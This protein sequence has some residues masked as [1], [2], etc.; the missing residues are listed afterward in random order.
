[1]SYTFTVRRLE[2]CLK[3]SEIS[4]IILNQ[5]ILLRCLLTFCA[6]FSWAGSQP[7]KGNKNASA[8]ESCS[9]VFRPME[10]QLLGFKK[11]YESLNAAGIDYTH[12][13][14]TMLDPHAFFPELSGIHFFHV[15]PEEKRALAMGVSL[16]NVFIRDYI[17]KTHAE[18]NEPWMELSP[19]QKISVK[20]VLTENELSEFFFQGNDLIHVY[21][22]TLNQKESI[23]HADPLPSTSTSSLPEQE[24]PVSF[25]R[26]VLYFDQ[27]SLKRM[28]R[29]T[30]SMDLASFGYRP[31]LFKSAIKFQQHL[32]TV[33]TPYEIYILVMSLNDSSIFRI[34]RVQ[35][36]SLEVVLSA[37]F[38][39][40]R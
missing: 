24:A 2:R 39:F 28:D 5:K 13:M 4:Q 6:S 19:L 9:V 35:K 14:P 23:Q 15:S 34:L 8:G 38:S 17:W 37:P 30:Y 12:L 40:E 20:P 3:M 16:N 26:Q 21:T 11:V 33:D 7:P 1:M 25:D 18:K 29:K 27:V 10:P 22:Q 32:F 36:K 31:V